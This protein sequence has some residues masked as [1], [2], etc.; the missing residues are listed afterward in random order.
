MKLNYE[1]IAY[2]FLTFMCLSEIFGGKLAI[3]QNLKVDYDGIL[4]CY[5]KI[6]QPKPDFTVTMSH[7]N[8]EDLTPSSCK[9]AC[10]SMSYTLATF[11]IKPGESI[12][13][14]C[15]CS[16]N[17]S[18]LINKRDLRYCSDK[19]CAGNLDL[20]CGSYDFMLVYKVSKPYVIKN[21]TKPNSPSVLVNTLSEYNVQYI[22]EDTKLISNYTQFYGLANFGIGTVTLGSSIATFYDQL[23]TYKF[24]LN[25]IFFYFTK[26]I[27]K[28]FLG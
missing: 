1:M 8:P 2:T 24:K 9:L 13:N 3:A 12:V 17:S 21:V 25:Y 6:S 20:S 18:I 26:L 4:G 22:D 15:L 27:L 19:P 10:Q 16:S 5:H 11:D 7:L 14:S 23:V 28:L